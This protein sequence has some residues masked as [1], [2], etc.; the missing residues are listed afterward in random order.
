[1]AGE[2]NITYNDIDANKMINKA[3]LLE[4]SGQIKGY[5]QAKWN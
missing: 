2:T 3:G 5:I 4:L 1:M